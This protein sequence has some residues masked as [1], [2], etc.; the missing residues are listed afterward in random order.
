MLNRVL[1]A[2][3]ML[4][5]SD[6]AAF[7]VEILLYLL[8][9]L[10]KIMCPIDTPLELELGFPNPQLAFLKSFDLTLRKMELVLQQEGGNLGS[11]FTS[12]TEDAAY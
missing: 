7:S 11:L 9:G 12:C 1:M 2:T 3:I 6:S 10:P 8:R 5:G 4:H